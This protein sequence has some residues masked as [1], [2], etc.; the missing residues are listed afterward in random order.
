MAPLVDLQPTSLMSQRSHTVEGDEFLNDIPM[1][2]HQ[3]SD[4][5]TSFL[6][7]GKYYEWK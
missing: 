7:L 4:K 1:E 6:E 2:I 3:Q 5:G